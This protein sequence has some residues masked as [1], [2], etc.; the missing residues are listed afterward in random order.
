MPR[1][2]PATARERNPSIARDLRINEKIRVREVLIIDDEG[3]KLGVTPI[4]QALEMAR[5]R[6]L[7]LVEVA[8][9]AN[10]PVCLILDYGKFKY[11]QAKQERDA[12]KHQKQAQLRDVRF[13]T[14]IGQPDLGFK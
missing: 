2:P 7:D 12:H 1:S 14:K 9:N 10:P 4:F 6:G 13:T 5:E 11:E 8:P 3:Q